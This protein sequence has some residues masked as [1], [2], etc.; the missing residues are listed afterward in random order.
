MIYN[1]E[2]YYIGYHRNV[3]EMGSPVTALVFDTIAGMCVNSDSMI[4]NSSL[5]QLL[6]VTE[7]YVIDQVNL[8]ITMGYIEKIAGNGRGKK[9]TYILTEKGEQNAPLFARKR[10]NKTTIKGEQ[11]DTLNNKEIKK[12]IN[13]R[14]RETKK[15]N[16]MNDFDLFWKAFNVDDEHAGE[17]SRCEAQWRY[18]EDDMKAAII[19]ELEAGK[20]SINTPSPRVYL[21]NY[22]EQLPFVRQGTAAFTKWLDEHR[23]AGERI[24]MVKYDGR[25]AWC[26]ANDL[27]KMIDAGAELINGDYK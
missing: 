4:S 15:E 11:N 3:R 8:L 2:T 26:L 17:R 5:A 19:K 18:M 10:V 6:G 14:T 12:S 24:C 7:R 20:K 1:E 22:K 27:P 25:M 9:T 13:S 16:F 23:S 21:Y